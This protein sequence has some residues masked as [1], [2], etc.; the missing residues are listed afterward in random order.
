MAAKGNGKMTGKPVTYRAPSPASGVQLETFIPWTLVKRRVRREIIT[1]LDA[2]GEFRQEAAVEHRERLAA[3]DT[4]LLRA[5]G[6]AHHWQRLLDE[7]R[8][9][10]LTEIAEAE[11]I[12]LAQASRISRLVYLGPY[13]V[14]EGSAHANRALALECL[15]RRRLPYDWSEQQA[16]Y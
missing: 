14:E 1:P 4:P 2:P 5:L 6:L 11:G 10:S 7:A 8:F 13:L 12:D 3:Q 16:K 15:V 9:M